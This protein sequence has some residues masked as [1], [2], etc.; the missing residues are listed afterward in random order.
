M[1]KIIFMILFSI[2]CKLLPAPEGVKPLYI[3]KTEPINYYQPLIKAIVT[4]ESKWNQNAFNKKELAVSWFQIR[5]CRVQ[6]FNNQTGKHYT[7]HDMYNF[8]KAQE[9]FMHFT[10]GRNYET[11]ARC[12]NG[13]DHGKWEKTNDYWNKV[14]KLI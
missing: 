10:K 13:G 11:V 9:V 12:W 8:N 4:V 1:K 14:K 6:D 5:P 3:I 2:I 7:L